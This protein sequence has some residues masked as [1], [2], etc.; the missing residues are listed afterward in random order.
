M[1]ALIFFFF[2]YLMW[3]TLFSIFLCLGVNYIWSLLPDRPVETPTKLPD[4]SNDSSLKKKLRKTG[5]FYG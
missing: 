5:G 1:F 4:W 2:W 3:F